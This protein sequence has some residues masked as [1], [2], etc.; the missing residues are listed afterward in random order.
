MAACRR[1]ASVSHTNERGALRGWSR[2][3]SRVAA[4]RA[5]APQQQRRAFGT[6]VKPAGFIDIQKYLTDFEGT[7][8]KKGPMPQ[9]KRGPRPKAYMEYG[10]S[11]VIRGTVARKAPG[12]N[13]RKY[14]VTSIVGNGKGWAGIG[15]A[16][17]VDSG[18][19]ARTKSLADSMKNMF[20]IER[21]RGKTVYHQVT[22]K[23]GATWVELWPRRSGTGVKAGKIPSMLM[24]RLG[25]TDVGI[26]IRG[27][28]NKTM[29]LKATIKALSMIESHEH[30]A[31][32]RGVMLPRLNY[33]DY[34]RVCDERSEAVAQSLLFAEEEPGASMPGMKAARPR[35]SLPMMGIDA[36][37]TDPSLHAKFNAAKVAASERKRAHR[38]A[39]LKDVRDRSDSLIYDRIN[40]VGAIF[41]L[42]QSCAKQSLCV[43]EPRTE[44]SCMRVTVRLAGNRGLTKGVGG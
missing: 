2:C 38:L 5:A 22:T 23:L 37:R 27:S 39:R 40:E 28:R 30:A 14:K 29:Q 25:I 43:I 19:V 41:P 20:Y 12:G 10:A 26:K 36:V 18:R 17:S 24:Q 16:Q 7:A 42:R 44:P 11:T 33:H 15:S 6:A 8:R 1:A 9:G 3:L 35:P 31:K 32:R 4:A 34:R 13:I 21:Y